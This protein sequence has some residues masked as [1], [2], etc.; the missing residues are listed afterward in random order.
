A[1]GDRVLI[2]M[3]NIIKDNLRVVDI[4]ARYS[5]EEFAVLLADIN[6]KQAA[7]VAEKLRDKIEKAVFV[8]RRDSPLEMT[9]LTVSA[10]V[11]QY[12]LRDSKEK[13]LKQVITVLEEAKRKGKNRVCVYK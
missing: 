10:G 6:L 9:R 1:M 11:G 8:E 3:A 4:V 12:N 2:Q 7:T 5:G 13:F